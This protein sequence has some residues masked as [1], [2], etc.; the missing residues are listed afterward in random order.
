MPKYETVK[1]SSYDPASLADQLTEKSNEGWE[2]VAIV[3][4]GGDVTAFIRRSDDTMA[5]APMA[6]EAPATEPAGYTPEPVA[7][8]AGWGVAPETSSEP[9]PM[10]PISEPAAMPSSSAP[11][12]V[13]VFQP[14]QPAATPAAPAA[15]PS[16]PT[17]PPGWYAD[18]SG[19]YEQRY[20]DGGNW[21]EHVA[22]GGAQY[23]DPPVA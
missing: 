15:T 12:T 5:P 4:T 16:T 10:A 17:V 23:T 21:T 18:P 11:P 7:E 19:R 9:A 6:A 13:A 22:R 8:P 1:A 20:W 14:S 2:V 3:P